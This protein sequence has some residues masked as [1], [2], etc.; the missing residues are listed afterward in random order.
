MTFW[1]VKPLFAARGTDG[2]LGIENVFTV[3]LMSK[4]CDI[5]HKTHAPHGEG[6]QGTVQ[7]ASSDFATLDLQW[8]T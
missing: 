4:R 5:L 2:D 7:E 1:T 3:H 8:K 6:C